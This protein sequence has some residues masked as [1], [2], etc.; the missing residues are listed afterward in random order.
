MHQMDRHINIT[1]TYCVICA[2]QLYYQTIIFL[3]SLHCNRKTLK[4]LFSHFNL[5]D[6]ERKMAPRNQI[7]F[8]IL[9]TRLTYL[10]QKGCLPAYGGDNPDAML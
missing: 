10:M 6:F 1:H 8:T 2:T 3:S 4:A 7:P 5:S 9:R